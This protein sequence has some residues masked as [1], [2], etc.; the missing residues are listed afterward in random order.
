LA[1]LGRRPLPRSDPNAISL[2]HLTDLQRLQIPHR[3]ALSLLKWDT[4]VGE[5]ARGSKAVVPSAHPERGGSPARYRTL[6]PT[7]ALH[8]LF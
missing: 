4:R 2:L 7:L 5:S 8:L 3:R 6:A 1:P